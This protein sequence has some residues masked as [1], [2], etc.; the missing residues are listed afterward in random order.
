VKKEDKGGGGG[1]GGEEPTFT[2]SIPYLGQFLLD[3][4]L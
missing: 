3:F 4:K 2:N 1:E